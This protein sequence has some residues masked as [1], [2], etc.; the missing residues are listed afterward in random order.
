MAD[1]DDDSEKPFEATPHKLEQARRKG[2]IPQSRD[3]LA[4]SVLGGFLLATFVVGLDG[5]RRAGTLGMVLLEGG[6]PMARLFFETG[7]AAAGPVMAQLGLSLGSL[8]ILPFLAVLL[9]MWVFGLY[10][11]V[12]SKIAPKLSR[13]SPIKG[14]QNKFGVSGLYEF[15]KSAV[16]LAVI[17]VVLGV[18]LASKLDLILASLGLSAAVSSRLIGVLLVEFL[19]IVV[20]CYLAIGAID[21]FWQR[22]QHLRKN[23]MSRKELMDEMKQ[24]EGDPHLKAQRR[25][26]GESIARNN[27][28]RD[29]PGADVVVVNPTHYAVA[30]KWNRKGRGAPVCVAKGVDEVAARIR[31]RAIESGVPIHSAPLTARTLHALVDIGEEVP[32]ETYAAVAASIRF[33]DA[34]RRKARTRGRWGRK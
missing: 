32:A 18:Y 33:A 17:S 10:V 21:Y 3:L 4:V 26:K 20:L 1:Q 2:E 24:S 6:D 13:I 19:G 14:F 27:M 22:D 29:V 34:M 28:M 8:L 5:L 9:A 31:E 15:V 25:Q 16:K 23:R 11:P 12:A 7:P 30:L